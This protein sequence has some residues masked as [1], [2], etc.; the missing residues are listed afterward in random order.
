MIKACVS[1][2]KTVSS[3]RRNHFCLYVMTVF[4]RR[5]GWWCLLEIVAIFMA[6][7][8]SSHVASIMLV[9]L[10]QPFSLAGNC[11]VIVV[12]FIYKTVPGT[13]AMVAKSM[14]SAIHLEH[15]AFVH[16]GSV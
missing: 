9:G 2:K 13:T 8:R 5:W 3:M 7:A 16:I 14:L 6:S 10:R 1:Q 11:P 15:C 12:T 4:I